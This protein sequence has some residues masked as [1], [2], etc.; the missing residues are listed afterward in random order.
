MENEEDKQVEATTQSG[1]LKL[2]S[3][4]SSCYLYNLEIVGW[5]DQLQCTVETY[6]MPGWCKERNQ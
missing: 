1:S 4:H 2:L 3:L 5:F 6:G